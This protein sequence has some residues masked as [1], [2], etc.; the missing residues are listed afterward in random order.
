LKN[1]TVRGPFIGNGE[2]VAM[3]HFIIYNRFSDSGK[4]LLV[5]SGVPGLGEALGHPNE[6]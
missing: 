4:N 3:V 5:F 6:N 2:K 1:I